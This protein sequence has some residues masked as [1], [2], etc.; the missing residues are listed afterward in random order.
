MPDMTIPHQA[1]TPSSLSESEYQRLRQDIAQELRQELRRAGRQHFFAVGFHAL[2]LVIIAVILFL[3]S[4]HYQDLMLW[5][6]GLCLLI[7]SALEF[8]DLEYSRSGTSWLD[9]FFKEDEPSK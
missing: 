7:F 1:S 5:A 4:H 2:V 3:S 6:A 8:L 9:G